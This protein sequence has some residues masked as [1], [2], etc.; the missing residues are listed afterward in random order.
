MTQNH[1]ALFIIFGGTGDLAY[2]KLY[3]ALYRLYKKNYLNEN[4][5]VIGT[6]R[7]K[8]TDDYYQEVVSNAIE[9]IK[10]TDEDAKEFASH[11]YYQS[12]NV[13]DTENYKSLL[14]LAEQ[15][16]EKY[17]IEG[18]RIF[19]LSVS[20]SLFG[21][22]SSH[23]KAQNLLTEDGFNRMIIE[24]PFGT[25]HDNSESLN[26]EILKSFTEEQ[27]YRID[28]Y[29]GKE[30]IQNLLALRFSNPL[31]KNVWNKD[32]I[33]NM[34]VTLA[35]DIGVEERGAYYESSGALRDMVQNHVLQI[36]S[37][38]LMEEPKSHDSEA[39]REVKVKALQDL[40]EINSANVIE[41]Y[42]RGQYTSSE[43]YPELIGYTAEHEVNP[44]SIVET[45][46]AGK[47]ESDN[48][49]WLGVPVYIRTGKRM[50]A[51][52]TRID[53]VF[54]ESKHSF[55][56][57]NETK[58]NVFSILIGPEQ[59]LSLQLNNKSI[60]HEFEVEPV[61]LTYKQADDAPEDYE[62]LILS[63]LS[64]EKTN[65]V[66]WDELAESWKYIDSIR[67]SWMESE[68]PLYLY[69]VYTNGPEEASHLL[70]KNGHY[71]IWNE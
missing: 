29:L 68:S 46:V 53:I 44:E 42:V 30:M 11:F 13:N 23:L 47:I 21:T 64:G 5:A 36:V 18:N 66:H 38:L 20:P 34:Q 63:A 6:A 16:D 26:N 1:K 32:F 41:N 69:E 61:N 52:S 9:E 58:D 4:F 17:N 31:L 27:I 70:E 43:K 55:L 56:V 48:D 62:R 7:R 39:I 65:F 71:W 24:K 14:H 10:E 19:Y 15:L 57:D 40:K 3:P 67:Q 28:H 25:D 22:I 33:S 2:R 12:H 35:E 49:N 45:F 54:K 59:G 8:W 60:G 50:K 37:F 51:K